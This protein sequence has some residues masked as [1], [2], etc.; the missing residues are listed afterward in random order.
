MSKN[1]PLPLRIFGSSALL[2]MLLV[3]I[4]A[5]VLLDSV[6]QWPAIVMAMSISFTQVPT[7][8]RIPFV[9]VEFD[10]TKAQQGPSLL[11][12]KA[13]IIGQKLAAGTFT[14]DTIVKVSNI[15][16]VI[17]GGGRGSM[18]H[19]QALAWFA[20]N[21]STELWIGVLADN[22]GGVAATGTIVVGGPATA[23]GTIYLYLGGER[24]TVGVT[25]GQASTAIASSI[26]TAI[27]AALDLPVTS[28]V[29]SSTVTIAFRHKGLVGNSYDVRHSFNFGEAL[30]A[31]VTLT[32]TAV[33]SVVAGTL[34]PVLTTLIA[35][36]TDM[37]F[38][39]WTHPYTDA[40][41]LTAIETELATRWGPMRRQGGLAITSMSGTFSAHTTLGAGRNSAFSEIWA[42]PGPAPLTPP[43]EFGAEA[44]ALLAYYGAIDPARPFQTLA[45]S[46]AIAP[47]ENDLFDASERN[48]FLFDGISPTK[49]GAGG[50]VQLERAITTYQTSPS[51]ADDTAY[52]DATTILTLVYLRY[53]FITRMQIRYPRHKLANDGTRFG[54]GQ[55]VM[56]P[57]LGKAEAV[58]WF[59]EKEEQGLVEGFDQFKRDL[60]V[61]RNQSDPNRLDF[62]LPPDL[63][64][65]LIVTAAKIQFLL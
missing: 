31:G 18:L 10:A 53:D 57:K 64:N 35:A 65:Q 62:L 43:M 13:I 54:A 23:D 12:Y 5:A 26:N 24:V 44:A 25:S 45:M 47:A 15:D 2:V 46:R 49:R 4:V 63:I 28:T 59:R 1:L 22:G 61:E 41:S 3:V 8:L 39:I 14:A 29:A 37:W 60:V 38:Q 36:M 6:A 17:T 51:S 27:N 7:N 34:N 19:R 55:A 30:P 9:A 16:Q 11:A 20:S 42:Q 32:I 58:M 21:K 56:T 40:T 48:L 52:L 33:G 50:I